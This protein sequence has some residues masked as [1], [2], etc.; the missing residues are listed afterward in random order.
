VPSAGIT[1]RP[2]FFGSQITFALQRCRCRIGC[3]ARIL[4]PMEDADSHLMPSRKDQPPPDLRCFK[5]KQKQK[6]K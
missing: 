5:Q 3:A 6:Q 2:V 1:F 4:A